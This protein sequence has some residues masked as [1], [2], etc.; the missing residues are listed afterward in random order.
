MKNTSS[1]E[2]A[3]LPPWLLI[4]LLAFLYIS[5]PPFI[6]WICIGGSEMMILLS[7]G[8][9]RVTWILYKNVDT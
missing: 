9:H 2:S 3:R 8:D 5:V 6:K 4:K 7:S 1:S